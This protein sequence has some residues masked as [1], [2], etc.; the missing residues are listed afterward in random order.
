[1]SDFFG[2]ISALHTQPLT[3]TP[4]G[5]RSPMVAIILSDEEANMRLHTLLEM[6][7]PKAYREA[8]AEA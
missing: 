5:R 8:A 1:M 7:A 4:L 2:A 6:R 3:C